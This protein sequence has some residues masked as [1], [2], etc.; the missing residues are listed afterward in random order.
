M[1][2]FDVRASLKNC[3]CYLKEQSR[4]GPSA[5][6]RTNCLRAWIK[7]LPH[8]KALLKG[9]AHPRVLFTLWPKDP[10]GFVTHGKFTPPHVQTA[11]TAVFE[12]CVVVVHSC[13]QL[14]LIRHEWDASFFDVEA[15]LKNC[16]CRLKEQSHVSPSA[17]EWTNC[18][19]AWIKILPHSYNILKTSKKTRI[20][21]NP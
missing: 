8:K 6:K 18:L 11:C 5:P 21:R 4:A 10:H 15:S 12:T 16:S 9:S 13:F 20:T 14:K 17:P 2:F 7:I 1:S 19:R 3:S